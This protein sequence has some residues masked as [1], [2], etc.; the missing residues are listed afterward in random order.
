MLLMCTSSKDEWKEGEKRVNKMCFIGRN[1]DR[2]LIED[3]IKACIVSGELRFK[4]GD[5]VKCRMGKDTWSKGVVL[6]LWDMGN[7]YRV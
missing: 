5:K 7:A 3:G 6:K 2:K 1:L 4:V